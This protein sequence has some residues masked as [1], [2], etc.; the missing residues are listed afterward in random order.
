MYHESDPM[1]QKYVWEY[2]SASRQFQCF[3]DSTFAC[4]SNN[5]NNFF[6]IV[7]LAYSILIVPRLATTLS[8]VYDLH[9]PTPS[10]IVP[11]NFPK[12][13]CTPPF[14]QLLHFLFEIAHL[15]SRINLGKHHL[16]PNSL[17]RL[18]LLCYF[19]CG[20]WGRIHWLK[21]LRIKG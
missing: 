15:F 7:L 19:S 18:L 6:A 1:L 3:E 21:Y 16:I 5:A 8:A 13:R 10:S 9:Q 14:F 2:H 17:F 4:S 20:L 11:F 12:P